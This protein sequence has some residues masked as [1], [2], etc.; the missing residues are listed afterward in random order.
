MKKNMNKTIFLV[1]A[2]ALLVSIIQLPQANALTV[3][4]S[5]YEPY[6]AVPGQ[7][8]KVWFL[9]QN[10][11][12]SQA[13]NINIE[14]VPQY[15][16]SLYGTETAVKTISTLGS[17]RDYLIDYTLKVD[18]N[19]VQGDYTLK[20]RYSSDNNNQVE[21]DL[22]IFVQSK[23]ATVTIDSVKFNPAEIA[24]G[25]EG[26]LTITVKNTAQTTLTDMSMKLYLQAAAAGTM[27]DLPFAPVDS[28]AEKR[29]YKLE[30]GQT[31]DFVFDLKAYP[32]AVSKV[33]KIP[34]VLTYYD[35][36]GNQKNKTDFIGIKDLVI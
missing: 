20:V 32:D 15:P 24:P 11:D 18:D 17:N 25:S 36:L 2:F 12:N 13:N 19:A 10:T 14:L 33:Y 35:T 8:V 16:F 22:S 29:I 31:T 1:L 9:V 27:I 26:T 21:Q 28:T 30:A 3:S 23:D 7:T 5:K 34:F 4:L 6:P